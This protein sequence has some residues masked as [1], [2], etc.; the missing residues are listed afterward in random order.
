MNIIHLSHPTPKKGIVRVKAENQEEKWTDFGP[1]QGLGRLT[2]EG[3]DPTEGIKKL[4][5]LDIGLCVIEHC[6]FHNN[7]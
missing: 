1:L 3:W 6:K 4:S 2:D 5:L 7:T